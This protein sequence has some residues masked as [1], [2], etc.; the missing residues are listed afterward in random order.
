MCTGSAARVRLLPVPRDT[1]L[2]PQDVLRAEAILGPRDPKRYD[3]GEERAPD[4][5]FGVRYKG[6]VHPR[7]AHV[8]VFRELRG[9]RARPDV[10]APVA[11]LRGHARRRIQPDYRRVHPHPQVQEDH[12]APRRDSSLHSSLRHLG[13][14]RHAP[15]VGAGG[16]ESCAIHTE[17]DRNVGKRT[18]E[19]RSSGRVPVRNAGR[20]SR[21]P[22]RE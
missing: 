11:V 12:L 6:G 16:G 21:D 1:S 15:R 9:V 7:E 2:L 20:V 4:A 18:H 10:M 3:N 22:D 17:R 13:G 19:F 14:S 8:G 5:D